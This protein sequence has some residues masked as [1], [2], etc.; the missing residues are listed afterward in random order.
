MKQIP[1]PEKFIDVDGYTIRFVEKGEGFPLILIH[2]LG[3]SL[4][5]WRFN[6]DSL[7]EKYH[8]IAFDFLGFGMSSKPRNRISLNLASEF[9]RSF[10]DALELPKASLIGNSLGG[11]IAL[12]TAVKIPNRV[13]RLI[14]VDNAGFG[15]KVSFYLR[16][17][18]VFPVGEVALALRNRLTVRFFLSRLVHDSK[19]LPNELIETVL[20]T[21]SLPLN[22]EVCLQVLRTGVSCR[23]L[24]DE[25]RRSSIGGAS[26]LPH[27][28]LIVWG[29]DDRI[30][31]LRQAY[32]GKRLLRNSSLHVLEKCGHLPMVEWPEKFNRLV[33]DFLES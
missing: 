7:S 10:L 12:Q 9:M 28:I 8:V 1:L 22:A 19:R 26:S 15:S 25:I 21:F 29:E 20:R 33:L 23:G 16:L 2:G 24:K 17:G 31:P 6:L 5:W 3:A 4:E 11:L 14:L 30:T 18:S 32:V 13:E 27:K